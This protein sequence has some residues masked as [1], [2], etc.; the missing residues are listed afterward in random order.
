MIQLRGLS[1]LILAV[2]VLTLA[3]ALSR[4][5]SKVTDAFYNKPAEFKLERS[6]K[7]SFRSY[8]NQPEFSGFYR[9]RPGEQLMPEPFFPIGWS[10][11]GK[12]A[13]FFERDRGDCDCYGTK[14]SYPRPQ[15]RQS[16]LV[17]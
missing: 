16:R 12:F 15:V 2:V 9:Q 14:S 10:K 1:S 3:G 13:Y 5:Q 4:G 7:K 17:V 6:I 8:F 11:D